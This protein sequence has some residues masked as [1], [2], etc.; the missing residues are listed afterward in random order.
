MT[1]VRQNTAFTIIE[2]MIVGAGNHIDAEPFQIFEQL[3]MCRH[4]G[5]L[6]DAG[7]ALVPAVNR[8]FEI[9]ESRVGLADYP[10]QSEKPFFFENR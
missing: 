3:R 6:R 4:E 2:G 7:C 8:S 1:E 9:S 5:S 10:D